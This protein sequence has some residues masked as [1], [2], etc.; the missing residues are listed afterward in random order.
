MEPIVVIA[1]VVVLLLIAAAAYAASQRKKREHLRERFGPEYERTV[2]R[3][4]STREAER[5]LAE[6]EQFRDQLRLRELSPAERD[7]YCQQWD[8]VQSSFVDRPEAAVREADT[9]VGQVMR[10]RGYPVDDFETQADLVSVDH[11]EIVSHYRRAH[12]VAVRND[13]D[14]TTTEDRREAFVHFR[15]LFDNL[16]GDGQRVQ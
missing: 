8:S 4:D 11:P 1:L 7:R 13:R 9:L 12:E 6:R 2:E 16:L 10:D 3:S 14:G 15:A 5:D